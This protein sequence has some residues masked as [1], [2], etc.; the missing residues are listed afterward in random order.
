[1]RPPA[2]IASRASTSRIR[3][4]PVWLSPLARPGADVKEGDVITQ[5]NGA[6]TLS[7]PDVGQLLRAQA[8]QQVLLQVKPASGPAR[9]VVVTPI[10]RDADEELRYDDWEYTRRLEVDRASQ[11]KIGY[12]HLRAMGSGDIAQWTRDYYPVFNRDGLIID[13][14][15]NGGGNIDSWLL[16]RLLRKA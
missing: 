5:V 16:G 12:L 14:R 6:S 8:G 4:G 11:N 13:V 7:A 3:I 2:G 15:H 9:N 10:G 1:M